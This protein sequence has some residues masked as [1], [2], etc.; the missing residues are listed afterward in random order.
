MNLHKRRMR[1]VEA[2]LQRLATKIGH[3]VL[4][5]P[6][7]LVDAQTCGFPVACI[8]RGGIKVTNQ[9]IDLDPMNI[10]VYIAHEIFHEVIF[11]ESLHHVFP[12][13]TLN[14][15]E[16]YKIN[17]HL[18][19]LFG[20]DVLA[21]KFK[22]HR[23]EKFYSLTV[24]Q[25]CAVLPKELS[26]HFTSTLRHPMVLQI[27][28]DL[29]T[30]FGLKNQH[31]DF[32]KFKYQDTY[33][34]ALRRHYSTF[35]FEN[36]P[37]VNPDVVVRHLWV[38]HFQFGNR[39][40]HEAF[41]KHLTHSQALSILPN[42][43]SVDTEG[44]PELSMFAALFIVN[45]LNNAERLIGR[46]VNLLEIAS[47]RTRDSRT[48]LRSD[49]KRLRKANAS[50]K[51]IE[52]LEQ[53]I[54][55]IPKRLINIRRRLKFYEGLP[56]LKDLLLAEPS[57]KVRRVETKWD[58]LSAA[59]T[60]NSDTPRFDRKHEMAYLVR[61]LL[62]LVSADLADLDDLYH[63]INDY[64][65]DFAPDTSTK[66]DG[67][68]VEEV[69]VSL[70]GGTD[71]GEGDSL[72]PDTVEDT[73]APD[74]S[75]SAPIL[76]AQ[77]HD[78]SANRGKLATLN[79]IAV[80]PDIF[81]AILKHAYEFGEKLL[82]RSSYKAND[83]GLIDRTMTFGTDLGRLPAS[84]L[85]RLGSEYAKLSFLVDLANGNLLQY[86]DLDP[87][88]GPLVLMLDCSGSMRGKY[89]EIAAGF[90][91]SM[92]QRLHQAKR[93]IMLIKF[94]AGIDSIHVWDKNT[95][96]PTLSELLQALVTPSMSGTDFDAV[97]KEC[98]RQV[99]NLQWTNAQGLLISDGY[100]SID[101]TTITARPSDMRLT[102]IITTSNV[103]LSGFDEVIHVSRTGLTLQLTAVGNALL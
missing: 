53:R 33:Y 74:S 30:R 49:L 29:R 45:T 3:D 36:L 17:Q 47:E 70:S 38:R 13:A 48:R 80:N 81:R 88:R 14:S 100:G 25:I 37:N 102:G 5:L 1:T 35:E 60:V 86:A 46:Q 82:V 2:A 12:A 84:E 52:S 58:C 10:E 99:V 56:K 101:D 43:S 23:D 31:K 90:C 22:G 92:I 93:G 26:P 6:I 50:M 63:K 51:D 78:T 34:H 4:F 97:L 40:N 72:S 42:V 15:A 65:K 64:A 41:G 79:T 28:Q 8:D 66:D 57:I 94:S 85:G 73:A 98:F 16:D 54:A 103:H 59:V 19:E 9:C 68:A 71:Y 27:A 77:P 11:D 75:Q 24:E 39:W 91:L 95:R 89:Y 61:L 69:I 20:Y 44:D 76:D 67:D 18:H 21:V 55:N 7:T 87:K 32:I 96:C 62:K 83:F